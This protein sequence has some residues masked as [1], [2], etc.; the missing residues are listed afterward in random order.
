V[1]DV[2]HALELVRAAVHA[3][4]LPREV[5]IGHAHAALRLALAV[6][7][8]AC[9]SRLICAAHQANNSQCHA[10]QA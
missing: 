9:S 3:A 1:L 10:P 2:D 5:E 4:L 7:Q 6:L 8:G